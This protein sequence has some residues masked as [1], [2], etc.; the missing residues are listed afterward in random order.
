[1]AAVLYYFVV[2]PLATQTDEMVLYMMVT[3]LLSAVGASFFFYKRQIAQ[4]QEQ[5][6]LSGKLQLY[7]G[8]SIMRWALAEGAYLMSLVAY[9][10]IAGD[11]TILGVAALALFYFISLMPGRGRLVNELN[12]SYSEQSQLGD[13]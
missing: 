11:V 13:Q 2:P 12:L 7:R 6:E 9:F 5:T 8:A 4:A 1:M 10:F 3:M